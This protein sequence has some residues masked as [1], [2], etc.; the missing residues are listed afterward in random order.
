[1]CYIPRG[2]NNLGQVVLY[3]YLSYIELLMLLIGKFHWKLKMTSTT[4]LLLNS[5]F[6]GNSWS[7]MYMQQQI[8]LLVFRTNI[9]YYEIYYHLLH[10]LQS[11]RIGVTKHKHHT[12]S[13]YS[14]YF[15][16]FE[17]LKPR[18]KKSRITTLAVVACYLEKQL[19]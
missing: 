18:R 7:I 11:V 6:K 15:V 3:C 5:V 19:G 4:E 10:N 1:M 2:Q 8:Y 16:L 9:W 14:K 17:H 13:L 12:K